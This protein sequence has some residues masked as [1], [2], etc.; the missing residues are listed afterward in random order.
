MK[1]LVLL[2]VGGLG[3]L[4]CNRDDNKVDNALVGTWQVSKEIVYDGKDRTTVLSSVSKVGCEVLNLLKFHNGGIL[5]SEYYETTKVGGNCV[6]SDLSGTY[7]YNIV[8]GAITITYTGGSPFT[9]QVIKVTA[10]ELQLVEEEE[11]RNN[12]GVLDLVVTSFVRK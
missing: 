10:T 9:T 1:K 4:A 5:N 6:K 3:L 2:V 12:D 11:D 7:Q 8:N